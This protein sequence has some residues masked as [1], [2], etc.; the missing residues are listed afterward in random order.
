[1][2]ILQLENIY[3]V[4]NLSEKKLVLGGG[5]KTYPNIIAFLGL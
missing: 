2:C 1:M 3:V 5:H 4:T